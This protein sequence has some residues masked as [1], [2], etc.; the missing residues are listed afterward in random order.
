[1]KEIRKC[2][3]CEKW[4][5]RENTLIASV[6]SLYIPRFSSIDSHFKHTEVTICKTC[7]S[8]F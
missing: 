1:M 4:F 5:K 3:V 2:V 6:G 8:Q 7:A